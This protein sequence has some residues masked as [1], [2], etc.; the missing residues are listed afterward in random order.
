MKDI[1]YLSNKCRFCQ[2]EEL[3]LVLP[4]VPSPMCDKYLH[5]KKFQEIFPLDLFLCLDCGLSQVICVV[6]PEYIYIDYIPGI[7]HASSGLINHFKNYADDALNK[8]DDIKLPTILDI[9]SNEG[10]LLNHFKARGS[11]VLGVEPSKE[12]SEIANSSGI[13]TLTTY[14]NYDTAAQIKN[15]Y[16]LF[17]II[18]INNLFANIDNVIDFIKALKT[19]LS[20]NGLIV[21]E[22]AYLGNMLKNNMFDFIYHEHL[23][24]ITIVPLEK[25]FNKYGMKLVD[26]KV[27]S[28]KGGSMRYYFS[29]NN[30]IRGE[31][32]E[33][34]YYRNIEIKKLKLNTKAVFSEMS[35]NMVRARN[36][37]LTYL[38]NNR[39]KKIVGYG[40]SATSTTFLYY[41]GIGGYLDALVDENTEK[42]GTYSPGLHLKVFSPD[43]IYSN[44]VDS[45]VIIAWR[46]SDLIIEKLKDFKGDIIVPLPEFK[47]IKSN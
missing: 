38:L 17:D 2:S 13:K 37:L 22:S 20:S 12:I 47:V 42:I 24:C 30:S 41:F 10:I 4:L 15:K 1:F 16:G 9:G 43:Y 19:T 27:I 28:P 3:E 35:S 36:N 39:N 40:A 31:T 44:E 8:I 34:E 29:H 14:F 26:L 32:K 25:L 33:V 7:Y 21:I 6:D 46:F 23:S 11:T 5:K 18:T 45:I